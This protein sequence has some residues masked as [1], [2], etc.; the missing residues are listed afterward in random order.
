M[1]HGS[2]LHKN[3][4]EIIY[5]FERS[6]VRVV[7]IE[8]LDRFGTQEIF[9]RLRE[10]NFTI[11][12]SP[13]ITRPVHF[14]YAI[15]D[16]LFTVTDKTIFFDLIIPVIPVVN[17]ENSRERLQE[18]MMTRAIDGKKLGAIQRRRTLDIGA[19]HKL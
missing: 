2:V 6:D 16:E 18:L 13:Q 8:D 11:R 9:F 4:D 1:N 17:S 10:I 3:V 19:C 12:H 15:R 7:V 14:I 5:C